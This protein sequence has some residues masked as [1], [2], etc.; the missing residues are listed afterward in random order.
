MRE[1]RGQLTIFVIL[2]I[3]L[4]GI[5]FF[6]F[7]L[8]LSNSEKGNTSHLKR[9]PKTN[10]QEF[11]EQCSLPYL[12]EAVN[13]INA[14]GGY[15][16][17]KLPSL[18]YKF[19]KISYLCHTPNHNQ[20]CVNLEPVFVGAVQRELDS[21]LLP[22]V[23]ECFDEFL[24]SYSA[25][26]MELEE[27]KLE[28]KILPTKILVGLEKNI[29]IKDPSVEITFEDFS[30]EKDSPLYTF[31]NMALDL[32]NKEALCSCG[33]ENCASDYF[34]IDRSNVGFT[35]TRFTGSFGERVYTIKYLQTGEEFNF[36]IRNC[37]E[38]I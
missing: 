18:T 36:A 24:S 11:I 29:R 31:I 12:E 4:I 30:F 5:V 19:E 13:K 21:Y 16:Y 20:N 32:S 22:R 17:D 6:T 8:L 37:I 9:P 14:Q 34:N 1:K 27:T 25:Y 26:D 33:Q 10:A 35:T 15:T 3:L 2:G 38:E 7:F 23:E 28:T